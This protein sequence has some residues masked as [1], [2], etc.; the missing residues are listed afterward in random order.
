MVSTQ[1]FQALSDETRLRVVL[2]LSVEAELSVCELVH[3]LELS[4]PK[5]S[6]HLA[7]LRDAG[8]V[9]LR[10]QAQWVHYRLSDRLA[11]WEKQ[12]IEAALGGLSDTCS[13]TDLAR[14]EKMQHRPERLGRAC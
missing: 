10:R 1:I 9:D 8:V 3:A 7:C 6:R 2:L 4:Q 14:L 5:I 12:V 13:A 11:P